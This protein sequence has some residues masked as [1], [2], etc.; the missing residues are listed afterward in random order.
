M[1]HQTAFCGPVPLGFCYGYFIRQSCI[2]AVD[3]IVVYQIASCD[4]LPL[5]SDLKVSVS[6]SSQGSLVYKLLMLVYPSS[7]QGTDHGDQNL[8][9]V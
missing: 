3:V 4:Q 9:T 8:T 2:Q 5:I 7:H 6:V 1:V